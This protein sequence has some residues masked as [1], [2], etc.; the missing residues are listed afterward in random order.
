VHLISNPN[1]ISI[2]C[3]SGFRH[4]ATS[5]SKFDRVYTIVIEATLSISAPLSSPEVCQHRSTNLQRASGKLN[6]YL[7]CT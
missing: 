6:K 4:D 1:V 2:S 3:V 5:N 7:I